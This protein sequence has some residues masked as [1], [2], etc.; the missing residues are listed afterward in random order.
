MAFALFSRSRA[1]GV[2][3]A[4]VLSL[5]ACGGG[6]GGSPPPV[7]NPPPVAGDT[8]PPQVASVTP[9]EGATGVALTASVEATY[10]ESLACSG[11][12][13]TV[14]KIAGVDAAVGC[15]GAAK[16]MSLS[17]Q[18]E[19]PADTV[20]TA[21]IPAATDMA[22]NK[23]QPVTVNYR[24]A[25][26]A[27]AT[28]AKLYASLVPEVDGSKAV[29]IVDSAAGTVKQVG[30]QAGNGQP[31][32]GPFCAITVDSKTAKVYFASCGGFKIYVRDLVTD[33]VLPSIDLDPTL[34]RIDLVWGLALTETDVCAAMSG[35]VPDGVSQNRVKC[36]DRMTNLPTFDGANN[37]LAAAD[38]FTTKLQ[39]GTAPAKWLYAI[40]AL[41]TSVSQV[42]PPAGTPGTLV[43]LNPAT[44]AV[45]QTYAVGSVPMAFR[46]HEVTGHVY[47]A[48]AGDKNISIVDPTNGRTEVMDLGFTRMQ[49]RPEDLA[50][51][52]AKDRVFVSDG[53]SKVYV[54]SLSGRQEVA[55]LSLGAGSGPKKLAI[56]G[57]ELWVTCGNGMVMSIGLDSLVVTRTLALGNSP[58]GL[59]SYAPGNAQ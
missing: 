36:F 4:A 26:K 57:N 48:N 12:I 19:L 8:T 17:P 54:Y 18:A 30:F 21:T 2:L 50:L 22:G 53:E 42:F 23:G 25:K 29:A 13:G 20:V 27:V 9:T 41:T 5:S 45:E 6:G 37:T 3:L 35:S 56:L 49:Q 51:A 24:T 16:K 43:R 55:Q 40:N 31:G 33:D 38:M 34:A 47:V 32:F 46:V 58:V 59:A 52:M 28:T 15:D 1:A 11:V 14:V 44:Y 7:A 10:N 39:Y